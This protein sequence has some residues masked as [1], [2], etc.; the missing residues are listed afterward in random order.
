MPFKPSRLISIP[1]LLAIVIFLAAWL[2]N[3]GS[4]YFYIDIGGKNSL[5]LVYLPPTDSGFYGAETRKDAPAT[6]KDTTFRWTTRQ[7]SL[8]LPELLLLTPW[9]ATVRVSS[10]RPN[11]PPGQPGPTLT[12]WLVGGPGEQEL[13]RF[14]TASAADGNSYTFNLPAQYVLPNSAVKLRLETASV[15]QPGNGDNR[16]LGVVVYNLDLEP[17]YAAYGVKGWL[18]TLALPLLVT[19]LA[20]AAGAWA[21]LLGAGRRGKFAAT[22]VVALLLISSLFSWQ[23][24]AETGYVAWAFTLWV[25]WLAFWLAR[26]FAARAPG[27]PAPFVYAACFLAV[28]PAVQVAF[29]RLDL[30][31]EGDTLVAVFESASLLLALLAYRFAGKFFEPLLVGLFTGAAALSFAGLHWIAV[32]DSFYHGFDFRVNYVQQM[33]MEQTGAPL[34]N[35]ADIVASPGSAVR[36]PPTF[37]VMYWPLPRLYG[38]D[39][40]KALYAWRIFNE[41]LLIPIIF[42]LQKV[43]G[44]V[45]YRLPLVLFFVLSFR[46]MA[47]NI[48]LAQPNNVLLFFLALTAIL[49]K[50]R[51]FALSGA[52]LAFPIWLKLLP[53]LLALY[54]L[55]ERRWRAFIG[56]A[57]GSIVIN[58][59]VIVTAGWD[60]TLFYYTKAMWGVNQPEIGL[61]GQSLWGFIGRLGVTEVQKSFTQNFP[62]EFMPLGYLLSALALA[63]TLWVIWHNPAHDWLGHLLKFNALLITTL[64]ISP[65]TWKHYAVMLLGAIVVTVVALSRRR[66]GGA[67]VIFSVAYGI[68]AFDQ[69]FLFFP[70]RAYGLARLSS[71]LF[72]FALLALWALNL[73]LVARPLPEQQRQ[74]FK[75]QPSKLEVQ[76]PKLEVQSSG[77]S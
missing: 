38:E 15:F 4:N 72:F 24:F 70:D 5:D 1:L 37:T 48:D 10:P 69:D 9:K 58:A 32:F 2:A 61:V 76:N 44:K 22:I 6:D 60:N 75:L 14:T 56:L 63:L 33:A 18:G 51:R 73:W 49:I 53:G 28:L 46:Q 57:L 19:L 26:L 7:A 13:A 36:M 77:R 68:L 30:N 42:M 8:D 16:E 67:L 52:A 59:L 62:R 47:Y 71:S 41:L 3:I 55:A 50:Q 23:E 54:Y 25:G 29:N 39:V 74:E 34:Y 12:A 66:P 27:I 17:D 35:P 45:K 64:V 20:L 31:N 43:A 21:G 40:Q 11:L 65:F